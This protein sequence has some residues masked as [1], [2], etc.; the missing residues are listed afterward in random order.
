MINRTSELR[1]QEL[2]DKT[3]LKFCRNKAHFGPISPEKANRAYATALSAAANKVRVMADFTVQVV[4]PKSKEDVT[5]NP[6][7]SLL[8]E[9]SEV[10]PAERVAAMIYVM[11]AWDKLYSDDGTPEYKEKL[12]AALAARS[13]AYQKLGINPNSATKPSLSAEQRTV[14]NSIVGPYGFDYYEYHL[15]FKLEGEKK[16]QRTVTYRSL[17][18]LGLNSM[19][20]RLNQKAR[21]LQ[22][23]YTITARPKN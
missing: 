20:N 15:A 6:N 10:N 4:N 8:L 2:V 11:D 7:K 18:P 14:Y 17:K 3:Y 9:F 23:Q 5:T 21:E 1:K 13:S 16:F 22:K 19:L 12:T